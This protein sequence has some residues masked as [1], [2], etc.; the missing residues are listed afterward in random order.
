[1]GAPKGHPPYPG[2]ET[3]GRPVIWTDDKIEY[4]ADLLIEWAQKDSSLVL[5][6]HYG[7]RGYSYD[8]AMDWAKRNEKYKMAKKV[9][10][11]IVGARREE[12]ALYAIIDSAIVKRSMHMY[13]P[14]LLAADI[15]LKKAEASITGFDENA[16]SQLKSLMEMIKIAQ[17][18]SKK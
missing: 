18:S 1:M 5:G 9:A 10:L 7:A 8:H 12:K 13:D 4:E 3:G 15:E 14:G 6:Q 11:T 16:V 17:N 2:C